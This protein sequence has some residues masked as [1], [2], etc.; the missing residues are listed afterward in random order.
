MDDPKFKF[1][2]GQEIFLFSRMSTPALKPPSLLLSVPG[3][4]PGRATTGHEV[5]QSPTFSDKA[6]NEWICTSSP[7][8]CLHDV[9]TNTFTSTH[10]GY[11]YNCYLFTYKMCVC[12]RACTYMHSVKPVAVY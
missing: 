4:C 7:P 11:P 1:Q 9:N 3:F 8:L 2:Q 6:K 5:D 10:D 12:M